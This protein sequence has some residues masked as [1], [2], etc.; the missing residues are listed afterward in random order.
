V[1]ADMDRHAEVLALLEGILTDDVVADLARKVLGD[2]EAIRGSWWAEPVD[3]EF[4]TPTTK[5][6]VRVRGVTGGERSWSV[7]VKVIQAYRHWP[8]IGML[9]PGLRQRVLDSP[10]W[11]YE[12]D[13]YTSEIGGL[14]P[15][16]LRMPVLHAVLDL[17]DDRIAVVLEDI[18]IA[19]TGWDDDRFA[20]AAR[21]LA[22]TSVRLTKADALPA[23]GS[24]VP[25]EM[26]R[27]LYEFRLQ[28]ADLPALADDRTWAAHPQMAQWQQTL[29]PDLAELASRIPAL[30]D[31]LDRLPQLMVH[32]DASPQNLLIPAC[33]PDSFVAIDWS[34]GGINA[35]GDDL[36]QLAIG[37]AHAGQVPVAE[38]PRIRDIVIDGYLQGL[39]EE[40]FSCDREHVAWGMDGALAIRSAFMALPL[41][42]LTEAPSPQLDSLLHNRLQ[43]TRYLCDLGLAIPL[44]D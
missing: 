40:G 11:R 9:P 19:D 28:L 15:A 17:G 16:G 10:L 8:M 32:G 36:A 1:S 7:F 33:E 25:G 13:A 27:L 39:A 30:L 18:A 20:Q 26:S 22:R 31:W 42:R 44:S 35:A 24:R 34:L 38:L 43:L 37:L 6:A 12:A 2:A 29:Q 21:L 3:Y 14:L 4:G 23:S 41:D 5:G